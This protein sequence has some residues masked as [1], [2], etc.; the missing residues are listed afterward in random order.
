MMRHKSPV[1]LALALFIVLAGTGVSSAYWSTHGTAA[2]SVSAGSV[3]ISQANFSGLGH[4]YNSAKLQATAL[5]TVKNTGTTTA[6]Y[7]LALGAPA[8]NSLALAVSVRTWTVNDPA[9]CN[10]IDGYPGSSILSNWTNVAHLTGSLA[11]SASA[12]YCVRTS[13]TSDQLSTLWGT[14]MVATLDL[15][16]ISGTWSA[17]PI[18]A[19]AT[20]SVSDTTPPTAP[21]N[22]KVTSTTAT[23]VT[24]TWTAA[25]DNVGVARYVIR[26]QGFL[27]A[28]SVTTSLSINIGGLTAKTTYTF[29][30][31]AQDA[32]GNESAAA[33]VT[34]TTL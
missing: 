13:L 34:V 16:S 14:T 28:S 5:I 3:G 21:T 10:N 19:T 30:V 6:S 8:N 18:S 15:S 1:A 22:L 9:L 20:Q 33:T 25:T 32:A 12:L 7:T 29:L 17:P 23:G 24:L 27:N 31:T 26:K 11:G 2:A 4:T